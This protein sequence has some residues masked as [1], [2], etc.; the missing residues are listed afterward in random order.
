MAD[1]KVPFEPTLP[2]AVFTSDTSVQ[3][4][5]FH[6]SLFVTID[7]EGPVVPDIFKAAV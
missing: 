4:E 3:A 5:P 2:L 6:D 7:D 1:V